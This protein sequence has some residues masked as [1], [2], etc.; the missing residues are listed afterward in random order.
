[1]AGA[2]QDFEGDSGDR[3]QEL[4]FIGI[5]IHRQVLSTELDRCDAPL[6]LQGL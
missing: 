4:V 3:R 6:L 1:M 5:D 2:F